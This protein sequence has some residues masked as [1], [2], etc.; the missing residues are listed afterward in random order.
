MSCQKDR[1]LVQGLRRQGYRLTP[2]RRTVIDTIVHSQGH[3]DAEAIFLQALAQRPGLHRSTV[4][5]TLDFM[6]GLGL[7]AGADLGEGRVRY[8]FRDQ[9]HH[10]HLVCQ[11][12]GGIVELEEAALNPLAES[13]LRDKGF[14][15]E[16]SHLA[17]FGRCVSCRQ[18]AS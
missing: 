7:V 2:Q 11:A 1:E 6:V 16:L 12:C 5:R 8:H 3:L 15:V 13:L 9:G 4:Y 17:L 14:A 18:E 10:H